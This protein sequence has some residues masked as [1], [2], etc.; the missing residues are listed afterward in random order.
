[1][2]QKDKLSECCNQKQKKAKELT[3]KSN[4]DGVST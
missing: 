1:M 2:F 3:Q 4:N